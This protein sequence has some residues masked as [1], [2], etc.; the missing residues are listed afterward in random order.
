MGSNILFDYTINLPISTLYNR[1][2]GH[3]GSSP[4]GG[5]T[6]LSKEEESHLV[7]VIKTMQDYNHP[8]SNSNVC[9]IA[10]CYMAELKKDIPDNG[11]GKDWFYG[12]M[13]RWS[14][15]LKIMKSMKFE[16]ARNDALSVQVLDIWFNKLYIMLKKLDLFDKPTNIFNCDESEFSDDPDKKS[17]VVRRER[18]YS[19]DV[20]GGSGKS[21]TA[22]LLTTSASGRYEKKLICA[23]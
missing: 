5:T 20:H 19:I 23:G 4:H 12:F 3:N 1:L 21:Q 8:V 18:R 6:I 14:S 11:P 9:T 10:W 15:E 16:K 17:V 2:P 7:Y 22:V 13:R